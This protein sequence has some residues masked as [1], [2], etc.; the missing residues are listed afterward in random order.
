METGINDKNNNRDLFAQR[1]NKTLITRQTF[2]VETAIGTYYESQKSIGRRK[3]SLICWLKI[4]WQ[5]GLSP[6]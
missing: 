2:Y 4:A 5:T 6:R 1:T 3:M